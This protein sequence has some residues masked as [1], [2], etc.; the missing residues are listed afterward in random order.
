MNT[1]QKVIA[2]VAIASAIAGGAVLL[3]K[4]DAVTEGMT[5]K[6]ATEVVITDSKKVSKT[7][8]LDELEGNVKI[9]DNLSTTLQESCSKRITDIL[10]RLDKAKEL[11][12]QAKKLGVKNSEE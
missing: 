8:T 7:Y 6:S 4:T 5:K 12:G 11:V 1:T 2:G 9:L 10:S 3:P